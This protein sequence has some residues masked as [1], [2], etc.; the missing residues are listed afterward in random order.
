MGLP[1]IPLDSPSHSKLTIQEYFTLELNSQE[2]FEYING[3]IFTMEGGSRMHSRIKVNLIRELSHRLRGQNNQPYDS[4]FRVSVRAA[5]SYFYP[6]ASIFCGP[7]NTDE[8]NIDTGTNATAVFEVVSF[9]SERYDRGKKFSLF[10]TCESLQYYILISQDDPIVEVFRRNTDPEQ[11]WQII[12]YVGLTAVAH[13]PSLELDLPLAGLYENVEFAPP[14]KDEHAFAIR[15]PE[16]E[17]GYKDSNH[18]V[19]QTHST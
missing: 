5:R 2:K 6:D 18:L 12:A 1:K 3:D 11:S 16:N 15:E 7:I 8:F 13:L 19:Y 10:R 14:P 4:D 17:Y 9:S